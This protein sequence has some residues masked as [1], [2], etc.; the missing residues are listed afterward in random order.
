M[1][2]QREVECKIKGKGKCRHLTTNQN[3]E[4]RVMPLPNLKVQC[5]IPEKALSVGHH[6]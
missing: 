2:F 5:N 1:L 4:H 3:M 6:S